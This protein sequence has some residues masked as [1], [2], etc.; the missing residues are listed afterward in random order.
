MKSFLSSLVSF[1]HSTGGL[2]VVIVLALWQTDPISLA[3]QTWGIASVGST[4]ATLLVAFA[5]VWAALKERHMLAH[6]ILA[7]ILANSV[8][9]L[10]NAIITL[11]FG[12]NGLY[13]SVISTVAFLYTLG[14]VLG[15]LLVAKPK[16][17]TYPMEKLYSIL[18]AA[19]AIYLGLGFG[20][21]LLAFVPVVLALLLGSRT[22]ALMYTGA[23]LLGQVFIHTS[24]LIAAFSVGTLILTLAF[25]AA[26][27][28]LVLDL[29]KA[30]QTNEA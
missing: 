9:Q 18:V 28:Y 7:L 10:F 8:S 26:L 22:V 24:L 1:A 19:V 20:N 5:I 2:V 16:V 17:T 27:A 12:A 23:T 11:N 25:A 4:L 6:L 29:V 30:F 15:E 13:L 21:L 14:V 3:G